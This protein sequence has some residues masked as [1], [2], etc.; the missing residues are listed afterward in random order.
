VVGVRGLG[1][2]SVEVV[3]GARSE[4]AVVAGVVGFFGRLGF[5]VEIVADRNEPELMRNRV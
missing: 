1:G 2:E 5:A 3:R 4:E